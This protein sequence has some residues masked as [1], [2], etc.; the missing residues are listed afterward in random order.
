MAKS[1]FTPGFK[2]LDRDIDRYLD[3]FGDW[4]RSGPT[5]MV[6][7]YDEALRK[8]FDLYL[9]HEAYDAVVHYLLKCRNNELCLND[10]FLRASDHLKRA[11][12]VNR[13]KR[14]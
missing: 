3:K 12:Q 6:R 11:G 13:L 4:D 2:D 10:D 7:G 14:L 1:S 9:E 8:V 5:P